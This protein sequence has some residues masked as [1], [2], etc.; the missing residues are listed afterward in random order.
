VA[1]DL[2]Q[3]TPSRP[4]GKLTWMRGKIWSKV[5]VGANRN[6][7]RNQAPRVESKNIRMTSDDQNLGYTEKNASSPEDGENWTVRGKLPAVD[8]SVQ[9][10]LRREREGWVVADEKERTPDQCTSKKAGRR[11]SRVISKKWKETPKAGQR[12]MHRGTTHHRQ[13]QP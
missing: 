6:A 7:N 12:K 10:R 11:G 2:F 3:T 1:Q 9:V 8:K 4:R 13:R 5:R